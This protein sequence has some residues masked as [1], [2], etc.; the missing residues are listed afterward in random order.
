MNTHT[1]P[2][3]FLSWDEAERK[4][5]DLQ[6]QGKTVVT[7]NGCFDILHV[8]HVNYLERARDLGDFLII[9]INS[10]A[11]VLQLKGKG[12]PL[13]DEVSRGIVLRALR[14][15]DAVCIF[16]EDTPLSWLEKLKAP[17]HVKGGDYEVQKIPETALLQKWGAQVKIL[18]FIEGFSTSLLIEKSKKSCG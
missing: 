5:R 9:G 14:S 11:S 15:V 4:V 3:P 18:P 10:D 17:L 2:Y 7:S 8:G 1:L 13:N 12:R 6:A 16:E